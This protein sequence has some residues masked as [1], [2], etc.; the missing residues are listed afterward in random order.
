MFDDL[1]RSDT[2]VAVLQEL[3][4]LVPTMYESDARVACYNSMPPIL[5]DAVIGDLYVE[6]GQSASCSIHT[7]V[8][9]QSFR[10]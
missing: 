3:A 7:R 4:R 8:H 10:S 1:Q 6:L 5:S 9:T 2:P